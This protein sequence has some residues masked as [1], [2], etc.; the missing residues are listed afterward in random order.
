MAYSQHLIFF[1]PVIYVINKGQKGLCSIRNDTWH[2]L[3]GGYET[4]RHFASFFMLPCSINMPM[5]LQVLFSILLKISLRAPAFSFTCL[6]PTSCPFI[7]L[8]RRCQFSYRRIF[9]VPSYLYLFSFL[10]FNR[11]PSVVGLVFSLRVSDYLVFYSSL[12]GERMSGGSKATS[13]HVPSFRLDDEDVHPSRNDPTIE[14][15]IGS[16]ER[17]LLDHLSGEEMKGKGEVDEEE[18]D[19]KEENEEVED[20]EEVDKGGEREA[21][22]P[23]SSGNDYRPFILP[24]IWLINYF[25]SKMS[26]KVFGNLRPR[27]QISEDVP[28]RMVGK[29]EKCYSS[30]TMDVGFYEAVFIARLRL[31]LMELHRRFRI[32]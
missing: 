1:A 30:R 14:D 6:S 20:G 23:G 16:L 31:P 3:I 4:S 27:F 5:P 19:G 11:P 26:K 12:V 17:E 9:K 13:G 18:E 22:A 32:S 2:P 15:W 29:R 7:L 24:S 25:L 10:F 28:I 21:V 8:L